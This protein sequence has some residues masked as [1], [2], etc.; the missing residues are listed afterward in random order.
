VHTLVDVGNIE[1]SLD[2]QYA[3][4]RFGQTCCHLQGCKIQTLV[5]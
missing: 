4:R 2:T 3:L 1:I 5:H